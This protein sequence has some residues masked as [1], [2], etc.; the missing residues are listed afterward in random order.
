MISREEVTQH[1]DSSMDIY[2]AKHLRIVLTAFDEREAEIKVQARAMEIL[3]FKCGTSCTY[4][5][6]QS[7]TK[8]VRYCSDCVPGLIG[9]ALEQARRENSY[10]LCK[11]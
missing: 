6:N 1:I 2:N 8:K 3:A 5:K 4:V 11:P 10:E 9:L 7:D